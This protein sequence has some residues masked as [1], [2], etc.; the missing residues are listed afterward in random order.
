MATGISKSSF[1]ATQKIQGTGSPRRSEE[2]PL[3][4]IRI[5][6]RL[7]V[8]GP[9]V[10]KGIQLEG[11]RR[12]GK[13]SEM[14]RKYY[15]EGADEILFIDSVASLYG[16]NNVLSVVEEA[17]RHIFVPLTV[18]G[19][20]RSTEDI[21]DALRAGADKVA[22]NTAAL[23]RPEFLREAAIAFGSQC[24]VLSVQAMRQPNGMW[25]A[26]TDNARERTYR[27]VLDWVRQAVELGVGEILLTSV[28]QEGTR[29]GFDTE[30]VAA[31]TARVNVPVIACGGAGSKEHVTELVDATGIEAVA[32]AAI[33]HH[34]VCSIPDVKA[35]L[36]KSGYEVRL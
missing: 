5:I 24:I 8:K 30:L 19:G 26:Y 20:L 16:R 34:S 28:N 18:G 32:C 36:R 29:E 17:A 6:P 3:V 33:F 21:K 14:A 11:V 22:I 10:V 25:E 23:Q 13:P 2:P 12:V 35:H 15:A 9:D 7:D 1:V 27:D 4:P 31:V